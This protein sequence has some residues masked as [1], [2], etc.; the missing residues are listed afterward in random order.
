MYFS[1][2]RENSLTKDSVTGLKRINGDCKGAIIRNKY[3]NNYNKYFQKYVIHPR[4]IR[5]YNT[6]PIHKSPIEISF[7]NPIEPFCSNEQLV[8]FSNYDDLKGNIYFKL[9]KESEYIIENP[10]RYIIELLTL[11]NE[12]LHKITKDTTYKFKNIHQN[13]CA[14]IYF[15]KG[16]NVYIPLTIIRSSEN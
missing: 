16:F 9:S 11:N 14:R 13:I 2:I 4:F 15:T 1:L 7:N 8:F 10:E 6:D 5:N 3:R 12:I